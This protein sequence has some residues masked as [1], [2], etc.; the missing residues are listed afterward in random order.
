MDTEKFDAIGRQHTS[1][2]T[3]VPGDGCRLAGYA[4]GATTALC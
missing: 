4:R 1:D 2:G 3:L